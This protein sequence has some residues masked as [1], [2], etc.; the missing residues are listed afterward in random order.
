M[1]GVFKAPIDK[2][3]NS[4]KKTKISQLFQKASAV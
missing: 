4:L 3:A 2:I 1:W